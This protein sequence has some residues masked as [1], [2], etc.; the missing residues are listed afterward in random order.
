LARQVM[1]QERDAL[2]SKQ[3]PSAAALQTPLAL[4]TSKVIIEPMDEATQLPD[5]TEG[6]SPTSAQ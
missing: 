1:S 5:T 3:A 6:G 4:G 2:G